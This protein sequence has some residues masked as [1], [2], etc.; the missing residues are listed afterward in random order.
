MLRL[1]HET[2]W[3]QIAVMNKEAADDERISLRPEPRL[4]A[5]FQATGGGA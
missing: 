3:D 5:G 4:R 1:V 2:L